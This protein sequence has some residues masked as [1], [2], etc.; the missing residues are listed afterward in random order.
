MIGV[1]FKFSSEETENV[2]RY[3]KTKSRKTWN[4]FLNILLTSHPLYKEFE[5]KY[6]K[7]LAPW[8]LEEAKKGEKNVL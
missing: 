2:I 7:T 6:K 8:K 3:A 1:T 4:D 5:E